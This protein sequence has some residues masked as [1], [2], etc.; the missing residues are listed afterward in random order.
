MSRPRNWYAIPGIPSGVVRDYKSL[1]S[2][3]LL[4]TTL[5]QSEIAIL[6]GDFFRSFRI[7]TIPSSG[8]YYAKF[9]APPNT[10][11]FGL[12]SRELTPTLSGLWYRVRRNADITVIPDSAW[13]VYNENGYSAKT[14]QAVIEDVDTVIDAGDITDVAY[15]PKGA[16]QRTSGSLNRGQG[17]KI[18]PFGTELLLEF[19]NL[20]NQPNEVLIYYQ[21]IEAPVDITGT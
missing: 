10:V 16:Q 19:E 3:R 7:V 12:V 8:T 1:P 21:W 17:F 5:N 18:V 11:A 20:E 14:G 9:T 13:A 15:I 6:E 2:G 4:T